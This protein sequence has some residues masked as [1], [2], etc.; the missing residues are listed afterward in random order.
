MQERLLHFIWQHQ[1]FD[2][3]KLETSNGDPVQVI[4]PGEHNTNRGPDFLNAEILISGIQWLGS[5][6]LHVD[7]VLWDQHG[8]QSDPLYNNVILH[9]SWKPGA[10]VMRNDGSVI[11]CICLMERTP[12]RILEKYD[13]L[14]GGLPLIPCMPQIKDAKPNSVYAALDA[15]LRNRQNSRAETVLGIWRQNNRD[16]EKTAFQ[17]LTRH[18]G[19]GVNNESFEILACSMDLKL[20]LRQRDS[21]IRVEALLFGMGGFLERKNITDSYYLQLQ[22]EFRFMCHKYDLRPALQDFEWKF[23]RLRPSNFPTV[24]IAQLAA[25]ITHSHN[26]LHVLMEED[27][28]LTEDNT[29]PSSYWNEH[30]DFGKKRKKTAGG[31]GR[32]SRDELMMNTILPLRWAYAHSRGDQFRIGDLFTRLYNFPAENNRITRLWDQAGIKM[33]TALDSQSYLALFQSL[34]SKRKC[35]GCPVGIN[36][37]KRI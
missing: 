10:D 31:M 37:L 32:Q 29:N 33:K 2:S 6:E 24:R 19:F 26:L 16:W 4:N 17:W 28:Y 14:M 30:Y 18:F 9:V 12:T 21:T 13:Q 5:V 35:L 22:S 25:F 8:H 15:Q 36:L 20:L 7:P 3:F 11:P 1:Y 27:G 34:C 23:L